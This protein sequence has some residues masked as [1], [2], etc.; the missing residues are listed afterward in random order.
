MTAG[1]VRSFEREVCVARRPAEPALAMVRRD[2]QLRLSRLVSVRQADRNI[3]EQEVAWPVPLENPFDAPGDAYAPSPLAFE[4]DVHPATT[5]AIDTD[6]AHRFLPDR[7]VWIPIQFS[8][9]CCVT[10][11]AGL[12][13]RDRRA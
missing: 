9:S 10:P 11:A 8:G 7:V 5:A 6:P 2:Q 1:A 13:A 12:A 4:P 3:D